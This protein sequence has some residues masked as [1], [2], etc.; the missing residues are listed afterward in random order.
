MTYSEKLKDPRWQKKRL[1]ILQRD[2]FTCQLCGDTETTLHIHHKKYFKNKEPWDINNK[3]L[4]TLCKHCH[5]ELSKDKLFKN[6][7]YSK[8]R[9]YKSDGWVDESK[10]IFVTILHEVC[11]M[12]IYD[13]ND[14]F[15]IGYNIK[16][17]LNNIID[18]FK[19]AL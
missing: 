8:I 16:Y 3:Y 11:S 1:E 17:D 15:I 13:K 9:I 14:N 19:K 5:F 10:I 12:T 2:N 18:I 4:V 7:P 6:V